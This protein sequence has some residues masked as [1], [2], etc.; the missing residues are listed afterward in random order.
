[1]KDLN[2]T[3]DYMELL[4]RASQ[5]FL[6]GATGGSPQAG[7]AAAMGSPSAILAIHQAYMQFQGT[8]Q[9]L[10]SKAQHDIER[11]DDKL[12]ALAEKYEEQIKAVEKLGTQVEELMTKMKT[13]DEQHIL[14]IGTV[15]KEK[16]VVVKDAETVKA[17]VETLQEQITKLQE[18]IE[19]LKKDRETLTNEKTELEKKVEALGAAKIVPPDAKANPGSSSEKGESQADTETLSAEEIAAKAAGEPERVR[20]VATFRE[21]QQKREEVNASGGRHHLDKFNT[22]RM[23]HA[24]DIDRGREYLRATGELVP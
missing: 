17:T 8:A 22:W 19:T 3:P 16:E 15:E 2:S 12:G 21:Y 24:A 23:A 20:C 13:S 5:Q 4:E 6:I 18:E 11:R 10:I 9:S 7:Q 14:K 1:M